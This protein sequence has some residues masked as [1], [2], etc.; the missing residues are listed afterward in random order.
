VLFATLA[1]GVCIFLSVELTS[2]AKNAI[3]SPLFNANL[4]LLSETGYF[5]IDAS[6]KPRLHLWSLGIE[7]QFYLAWPLA[8]WLTPHRWRR[9]MIAIV[10]AGSF[11]LNVAFVKT[12]PQAT[13][14]LPF[15]RAWELLAGAMLGGCRRQKREAEGDVRRARFHLCLGVLCL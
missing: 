8:L 2:L 5:D 9:A 14:Y 7:E 15:T 10:L 11:A 3:A 6:L 12:H 4:M 1:A 13:F